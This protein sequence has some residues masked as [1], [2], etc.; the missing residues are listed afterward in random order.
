VSWPYV[1]A[2]LEMDP[3]IFG[4]AHG[5]LIAVRL[6]DLYQ[7]PGQ[8]DK[9]RT[10]HA[11]LGAKCLLSVSS[12]KRAVAT[13]VA[14]RLLGKQSCRG[15]GGWIELW[16]L[17]QPVEKRAPD[18]HDK[19]SPQSSIPELRSDRPIKRVTLSSIG[20]EL[21]SGRANVPS[22]YP[23]TGKERDEL[24]P[25]PVPAPPAP[26]VPAP[27]VARALS[28]PRSQLKVG[29]RTHL[30]WQGVSVAVPVRTHQKFL[31]FHDE[32]ELLEFYADIDAQVARG[33]V[34]PPADRFLFWD[35]RHDVR[36]PPS[37]A[38]RVPPREGLQARMT[39]SLNRISNRSAYEQQPS[40]KGRTCGRT[41]QPHG[42]LQSRSR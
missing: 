25:T 18:V 14:V 4:S 13:L 9:I 10:T 17:W 3:T 2:V 22:T 28:R 36:W 34:H 29:G 21:R 11:A 31:A 39:N 27:P 38:P 8:P 7:R 35:Q 33:E 19:W 32:Q 41:R 42:L 23:C 6:G 30:A 1:R 5:L 15:P 24:P 16:P 20:P 12:T 26:A 37:R 40:Q